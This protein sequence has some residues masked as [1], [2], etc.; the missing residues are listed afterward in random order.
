MVP[1][2]EFEPGSF[3]DRSA[4]VVRRADGLVFRALKRSAL[5]EWIWVSSR[6]FFQECM[7]AQQIVR[8]HLVD[9]E[10]CAASDT[11]YVATLQHERLP[12][13]TWPYEWCFSMLRDA[14]LL[15][16]DLMGR[17]LQ[18]DCILKDASAYNFQFLR[19]QP[20]L[21]DTPSIV[22]LKPGAPWDGYRQF[23]QMF[24]Y[25][26]MLQAWKG[27]HFQPWLR[28]SLEGITP[29]QFARM[30]S[31]FDLFRSGAMTHVWLH[32]RLES[33]AETAV[34]TSSS[35]QTHGFNKQMIQNNVA[36]LKSVVSRLQWKAAR[37]VWSDYDNVEGPVSRDGHDKEVFVEQV[38]RSGR[39]K[40]VWDLGCN[41]GRYS[42]IAA[43]H[44][45]LVVAMDADHLTIDRFYQTLRQE[46]NRIIV[47]LVT[48]LSDPSPGL[49]WR[50]L[51]R[52]PLE[53]RSQPDLVFCLALIHHLVIGRNLILGDVVQWLASLQAT[54][55]IEFVDRG[56]EQ[57]QRLLRNRTDVFSD[58]SKEAFLG[59][60]ESLFLVQH[61]V[62]LPSGT[63]TLY[64]LQ[65]LKS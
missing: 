56:D 25:P 43:K 9:R 4:Q 15:Q 7:N 64:L 13:I 32:A 36:G 31:W 2:R 17:S 40:T 45:E 52:S 63:R 10:E 51:E 41:Q 60:I 65:P 28:G 48:D 58:Y 53:Q 6:T 62:V 22:R 26:L 35:L 30:L 20:V 33:V 27:I 47:P 34:S 61:Q 24:L 14:A 55:I 37:S 46:E 44:A 42:R 19:T 18:E 39:W 50:G 23:C 38:C 54:V 8:T 57:V 3:R 1:T 11:E 49:G 5:E 59:L 29:E 21:I 12:L 16:L